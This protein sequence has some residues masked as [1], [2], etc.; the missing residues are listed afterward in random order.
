MTLKFS[1]LRGLEFKIFNFQKKRRLRYFWARWTQKWHSIFDLRNPYQDNS[2]MYQNMAT[3][4]SRQDCV[5]TNQAFEN[6]LDQISLYYPVNN[7]FFARWNKKKF[8]SVLWIWSYWSIIPSI[9]GHIDQTCIYF[10]SL[11]KVSNIFEG[12][13]GKLKN[14][15]LTQSCLFNMVAIFWYML[16]YLGMYSSDRK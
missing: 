15:K 5:R 14:V 4:L 9:A 3:M 2:S 7:W 6:L 16:D 11:I 10:V 13:C 8:L 12:I 1:T